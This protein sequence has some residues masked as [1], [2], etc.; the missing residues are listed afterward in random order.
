[1]Q[2]VFRTNSKQTGFKAV[3]GV[4]QNVALLHNLLRHA[5]TNKNNLFVCLLD[6]SKAF[7][8]VSHDSIKRALIRNGCPSEFIDLFNNQYENSYTALSYADR[9][10][11]LI[12]L[13]RGVKQGDPMLSILFNLVID[14]LFEIIEDRCGYELEGVGSVNV[15]AFADDIALVSGSEVGMQ[16]LLS[17]TEKFLTARGLDLNVNKCIS[18]C[19]RKAGKAKKSQIA[20]SSVKN[21]PKFTLKNKLIQWLGIDQCCRYL[22]VQ[23]TPLGA[24]DSRVTVADLK[25]A[26]SSLAKV[27]LK[28]QQKTVMLRTY[29]IPRFIFSFTHTE[30]YSKLM[31]Q[32]DRLIRRW[33]KATLKLP[34]SMYSRSCN[35]M[36]FSNCLST[37]DIN[38][39]NVLM[40]N[41]SRT[42]LS[43]TVHGSDSTVFRTSPIM[44]QWLS[45]ETRIM[46]G[47]TYVRATQMRTNTTPTRVSISRG[48]DSIKTCRRC[49]LVDETLSTSHKHVL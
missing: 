11:R 25:S 4:G 1:M 39:S 19:L 26:L 23:F 34:S 38:S 30:C 10:S 22:G 13:N 2:S 37:A 27:P 17:E 14:E 48:R 42:R 6:V 15:R 43:E 41:E 16:Q 20:D 44:N 32:K 7:D 12:G 5:R 31:T 29:L 21:P 8:S 47:R 3:N 36:K 40:I 46:K 49:G 9:S 45:R 28:P 24:V 35:A 33:F 18:I